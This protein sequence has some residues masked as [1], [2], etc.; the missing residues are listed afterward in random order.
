MLVRLGG[1][2]GVN[3]GFGFEWRTGRDGGIFGRGTAGGLVGEVYRMLESMESCVDVVELLGGWWWGFAVNWSS[4]L[5]RS[6]SS[7]VERLG[8]FGWALR[9]GWSSGF[10]GFILGRCEM[11]RCREF[12]VN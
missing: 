1:R 8:R 12:E 2:W 7:L 6:S 9:V 4:K 3:V 5:S 11:F 10:G